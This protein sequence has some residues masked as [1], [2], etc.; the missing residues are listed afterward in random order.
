MDSFVNSPSPASEVTALVIDDEEDTRYLLAELISTAG[1]SVR[2][3]ANGREALDLLRHIRPHVVLTG[4]NDEPLLDLAIEETL[5]K[6][7]RVKQLL[8][9]VRRHAA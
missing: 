6:P 7:A 3:A 2:T 9:I 8:E 1:Y 5:V 4:T